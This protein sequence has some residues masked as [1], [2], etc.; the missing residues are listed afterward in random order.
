MFGE[1]G[2]DDRIGWR[3]RWS[4]EVYGVYMGAL[5]DLVPDCEGFMQFCIGGTGMWE[6]R[7]YD[8]DPVSHP[9]DV[10]I[11]EP[12]G[13]KNDEMEDAMSIDPTIKDYLANM[14]HRAGVDV[15]MENDAMWS[16]CLAIAERGSRAIVPQPTSDGNYQNWDHKKFVFGFTSPVPLWMEKGV[17]EV[18]EGFPPLA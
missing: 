2:Y 8:I 16:Y 1:C 17:W 3:G 6:K 13:Q 15:N 18:H 10:A 4:P 14:W 5:P 11:L 9:E 12:M 7:N